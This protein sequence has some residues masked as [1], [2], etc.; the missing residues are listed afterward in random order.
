[1]ATQRPYYLDLLRI[2]L[3]IGGW[4]SILHR[5][6]GVLLALA[7]PLLLYLFMLSLRSAEDYAAVRLL[8]GGGVGVFFT[9]GLSWAALHH[10]FAGLRHLGLDLDWGGDKPR[11]WQTA[12]LTL[13][14]SGGLAGLL[15][16]GLL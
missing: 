7:A 8:L 4:V 10:F 16:L 2:R 15:V 12:W 9:L 5:V 1:M 6:S 14:L 11:S 3:P 13:A